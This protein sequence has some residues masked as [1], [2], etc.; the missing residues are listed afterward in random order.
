ML[1]K[2]CIYIHKNIHILLNKI[3]L[4]FLCLLQYDSIHIIYLFNINKEKE[5]RFLFAENSGY[6]LLYSS[7]RSWRMT[8]AWRIQRFKY[9]AKGHQSFYNEY[10]GL[11]ARAC[12]V[13]LNVS[14]LSKLVF[15]ARH[16][17]ARDGYRNE[18]MI[19]L[20]SVA[21]TISRIHVIADL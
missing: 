4:I 5:E 11:C 19:S 16:Y 20:Q 6:P 3:P 17:R 13:I 7:E 14:L 12:V 18:I 21:K 2:S 1:L 8:K 15:A 9:G 10:K